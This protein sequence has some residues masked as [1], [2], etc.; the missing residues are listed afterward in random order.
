MFDPTSNTTEGYHLF[1]EP[2]GDVAA[3]LARIIATLAR[4]YNGPVFVPHITVAARILAGDGEENLAAKTEILAKECSPFSL[5]L[6]DVGMENAFFLALY[7]QIQK[8][9]AL[10]TLHARANELFS[11]S[12]V[13]PYVPHVSLLY[14]N[15]SQA[16]KELVPTFSLLKGCSFLVDRVY[17]Y[18]TE[19]E[20]KDWRKVREFPFSGAPQAV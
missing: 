10:E 2:T 5:T 16:E 19:G 14:G 9:D 15:F 18:R 6:G 17:L 7:M 8:T 13:S 4:E 20:T 12:D 3:E 1:L 11:L